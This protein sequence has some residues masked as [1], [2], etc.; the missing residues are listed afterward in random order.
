MIDSIWLAV[1]LGLLLLLVLRWVL[2]PKKPPGPLGFPIIGNLPY[3]SK[4]PHLDLQRLAKQYGNVYSLRLGSQY[5]VVLNDFQS[6][7]ETFVKDAFMGRPQLPIEISKKSLETGALCGEPWKDLRRFSLHML[8]DLGLG[9]SRMEEHI[10]EEIE[11]LLEHIEQFSGK[12]FRIR[13]LLTSSVS[14]NICALMFGKRYKYDDPI[15]KMMT[16]AVDA[17]SAQGEQVSWTV[18]FPW[19]QKTMKFLNIGQVGKLNRTSKKL[20]DYTRKEIEEHEKTLSLDITRDF[21]DGY[22]ME[23]RNRRDNPVFCKDVLEDL[24]FGFFNAGTETA[25]STVEWLVLTAAAHQDCQ[26]RIQS[27]IDDVIGHNR[28]P[29]WPDQKFMPYTEAFIAEV[30]RWRTILPLNI[31]RYTL[32]DTE[33]RGYHI[34]KHSYVVHNLWAV[35]HNP[36]YWGEDADEFRPERFLTEDGKTFKK[37]E[38]YMPFSIGKRACPGEPLAKVE[39]FLY[40]TAILQRFCVTLPEGKS[41]DMEG[42]LGISLQAKAQ[43]IIFTKRN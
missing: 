19:I 21:I 14:N 33:F 4:L 25:R 41:A 38:H 26:H 18:F 37:M 22:L 8:K 9:K 11:E 30:M 5:A 3:L 34:P 6:A 32:R 31:L 29:I 27:E 35:H 42:T 13:G 16:N 28:R 24:V 15:R 39:L 43:D 20:N 12:P 1:A 23:M 2:S 17:T 10:Q 40:F 36:D 7:K